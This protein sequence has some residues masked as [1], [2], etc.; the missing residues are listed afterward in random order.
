MSISK[1]SPTSIMPF[2]KDRN[3]GNQKRSKNYV[4]LFRSFAIVFASF[5]GSIGYTEI[6]RIYREAA[7]R[8]ELN[9]LYITSSEILANI[10]KWPAVFIGKGLWDALEST[11]GTFDSYRRAKGLKE[12]VFI[13]GPH[14]ENECGEENVAYMKEK[15]VE[16][17]VRSVVNPGAEYPE[18]K[19]FKDAVL[20]SPPI[21]EPSSRP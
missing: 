18:L 10:N 21:W 19:S 3:A 5:A 4:H 1:R 8:N 20:S 7:F 9:T 16:F 11:E 15:M 6:A 13:R 17:A 2:S 14:S 12:L